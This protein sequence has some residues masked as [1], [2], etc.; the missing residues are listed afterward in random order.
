MRK[1]ES[2][3]R[4][5][6]HACCIALLCFVGACSRSEHD[7]GQQQAPKAAAS[8]A[9][10][11][12]AADIVFRGGTVYA[13]D[14]ARSVAEAAAVKAGHIVAIGSAQEIGALIGSQTEVVE[15]AGGMLLPGF[16]DSH[17]HPVSA[18]IDE[19]GCLITEDMN[20]VN[21][22]LDKVRSCA[23]GSGTDW[24]VGSGW[25]L[26]LFPPDGNPRKA[27]LDAIA[28]N[29]PVFLTGVD[30]HSA[31]VNSAAL[32]A[33]GITAK[34]PN[35]PHGVIER[36]AT[37]EPTGTLRE[38]AMDLVSKLLPTGDDE[39]AAKA[40][41]KAVE[42]ANA[43]GITS[44]IEAAAGKREMRAYKT[45]ADRGELNVRVLIS[46]AYAAAAPDGSPE[47]EE[48]LATREQYRSAR[49]QPDAVKIFVDG[50][51][52]GETA[53][54]LEPYLDRPGFLGPLNYEPDELTQMV[55]R[56]DKLGLQVHMHAIGDRAVR[57][58]LD[59]I[60]AARAANGPGTW[61]HHIAHLQLIDPA[62]LPRFAQLNVA[63]NFEALWAFPD[64]YITDLNLPVVGEARVKRMYPIASAQR[65]GATIVG[66][67]DWNVSSLNPLDAIQVAVTRKD[68][69]GKIEAVLNEDERVDL[70]TMLAAY[71]INGARL[72]HQDKTTGS[73]EKGKAADLIVLDKNLLTLPPEQI[74]TAKVLRTLLDGQT[75]YRAQ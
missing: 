42:E 29:R 5:I 59:A 70:P 32:T 52:E 58:G 19:L 64:P 43:F 67:S 53:A 40:L 41:K 13:M 55:T 38:D 31:W 35:P 69:E 17:V 71:S 22:V 24:I 18:G 61:T 65:A 48:L 2:T 63:A 39:T 45:L 33:A 3:A 36:E 6:L 57:V 62:D 72:M 44:L 7:Q 54:L 11:E 16:H 26:S 27:L 10:P 56:I 73:I 15:L 1:S 20:T 21:A 9:S 4:L 30:G 75:V 74:R 66:G 25:N 34:T 37:G 28:P 14:E 47:F 60:A 51:L 68:P 23:S 49:V 12:S 46:I 8:P 50:V